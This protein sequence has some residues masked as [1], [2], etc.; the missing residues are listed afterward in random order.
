MKLY[1]TVIWLQSSDDELLSGL[2]GAFFFAAGGYWV[3]E[4]QPRQWMLRKPGTSQKTLEAAREELKAEILAAEMGEKPAEFVAA[5]VEDQE[6]LALYQQ[7]IAKLEIGDTAE[8]SRLLKV[9]AR[10]SPSLEYHFL[11]R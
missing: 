3:V 11:L 10:M 9:A 1:E 7:A 4:A 6:A 2:P 8:G 5:T